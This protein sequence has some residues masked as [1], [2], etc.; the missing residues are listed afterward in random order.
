LGPGDHQSAR[1]WFIEEIGDT[2]GLPLSYGQT[3]GR[4]AGRVC[5]GA[6]ACSEQCSSLSHAWRGIDA[7][8]AARF[9]GPCA[10]G[11]ALLWEWSICVI[12]TRLVE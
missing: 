1:V 12:I 3:K 2:A 11:E 10:G 5:G 6:S 4:N 7:V 9:C 8:M